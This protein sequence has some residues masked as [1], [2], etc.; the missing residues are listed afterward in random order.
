MFFHK[1]KCSSLNENAHFSFI[2]STKKFFPS[3]RISTYIKLDTLI[4][5]ISFFFSFV[6]FVRFVSD[7][8]CRRQNVDTCLDL[9]HSIGISLTKCIVFKVFTCYVYLENFI[10]TYKNMTLKSKGNIRRN[11]ECKA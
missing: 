9:C 6:V 5:C 4:R 8:L 1:I 7:V 10:C 3:T 2:F 11:N